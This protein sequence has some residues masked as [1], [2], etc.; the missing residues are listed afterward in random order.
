MGEDERRKLGVGVAGE[1]LQHAARRCRV[2]RHRRADQRIVAPRQAF[3]GIGR[4]MRS[5]RDRLGHRVL[6][7]VGEPLARIGIEQG[8]QGRARAHRRVGIA[9]EDLEDRRGRLG[10]GEHRAP[11][12]DEAAPGERRQGRGARQR[13]GRDPLLHPRIRVG[14]QGQHQGPGQLV[15]AQQRKANG[16]LLV[17]HQEREHRLG[18]TTIEREALSQARVGIVG[19]GREHRRIRPGVQVSRL[20]HG[21][22]RVVGQ[23]AQGV[24]R[25]QGM[26]GGEAAHPGVG[27]SREALDQ[28]RPA[29]G[30]RQ[31]QRGR[32]GVAGG[33]IREGPQ[34]LLGDGGVVGEGDQD[35]GGLVPREARD[36]RRRQV[37]AAGE[38]DAQAHVGIRGEQQQGLSRHVVASGEHG[39]DL[40]G[41][42]PGEGGEL[43]ARGQ[44]MARER[45][46][47]LGLGGQLGCHRRLGQGRARG[48]DRP[49]AAALK[50]VAVGRKSLRAWRVPFHAEN[51]G[52]GRRAR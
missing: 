42:V 3:E 46:A 5:L 44:G 48:E 28:R 41:L 24:G 23:E 37:A 49:P 10:M 30:V 47:R 43:S 27:G 8:M 21:R 18:R 16:G 13:V 33:R 34:D 31:Q 40:G 4:E 29:A 39:P 1:R 52:L 7:V 20:A 26:L 25:K 38:L 17:L 15:G 51:L 14:R 6:G 19:E 2:A 22:I 50:A 36:D 35:L 12:P 32:L 11:H 9:R 45:Q